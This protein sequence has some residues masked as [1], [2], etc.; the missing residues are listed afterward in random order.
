[1]KRKL[2]I[3]A[4][5][6]AGLVFVGCDQNSKKS[7]D[8]IISEDQVKEVVGQLADF[9]RGNH[10][11]ELTTGYFELNDESQRT[12]YRQLAANGVITYSAEIINEIDSITIKK[13]KETSKK[14]VLRDQH[15]FVKIEL[16]PAGQAFV[17]ADSAVVAEDSSTVVPT[18]MENVY[19]NEKYDS[20][21]VGEEG[22]IPVRNPIINDEEE[23]EAAVAKEEVAKKEP[24]LYEQEL[25]KVVKKTVK[26]N[27]LVKTITQVSDIMA[28][29]L[30]QSQGYAFADVIIENTEVSPFG[31]LIGNVVKGEKKK[32]HFTFQKVGG[33][34]KIIN[35][36]PTTFVDKESS[37]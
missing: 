2:F 37:K 32:A 4:L 16:T 27:T 6:C 11:V 35:N 20:D 26:V 18:G 15:V 21:N 23:S 36:V 30:M 24:S 13:G 5:A 14:A 31:R 10:Y 34:W 22:E 12:L 19:A 28:T 3:Y 17:I 7:N 8:A 1:M 25:E 33:S 9:Q 29:E